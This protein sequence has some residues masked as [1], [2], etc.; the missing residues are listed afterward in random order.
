PGLHRYFKPYVKQGV[1]GTEGL[2]HLLGK[3]E[4]D[5]AV[6]WK[7]YVTKMAIDDC[8]AIDLIT[9]GDHAPDYVERVRSFSWG[10]FFEKHEGG[11]LLDRWRGEWKESYDFVLV[12]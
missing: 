2:I 10:A 6:G 7:P 11:D 5:P 4:A 12:D 9:S 8:E 1:P 3:A